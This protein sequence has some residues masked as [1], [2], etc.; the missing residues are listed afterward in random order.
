MYYFSNH[1]WKSELEISVFYLVPKYF[2]SE[3]QLHM[4]RPA[5]GV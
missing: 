1:G 2:R 5:L 3:S 4:I